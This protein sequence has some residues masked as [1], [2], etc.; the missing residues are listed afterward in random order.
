M[1]LSG[2]NVSLMLDLLFFCTEDRDN[3]KADDEKRREFSVLFDAEGLYR[4]GMP[5]TSAKFTEK[6]NEAL[7][8]AEQQKP[9]QRAAET[10]DA[11]GCTYFP[12]KDVMQNVKIGAGFFVK[13]RTM[14]K[15]IDCLHKY[16]QE[17]SQT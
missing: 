6:L 14:N 8:A 2:I 17:G 7:L 11:F 13:I 5:V 4:L 16:K 12:V 15:D 3:D 9:E 10:A 1:L